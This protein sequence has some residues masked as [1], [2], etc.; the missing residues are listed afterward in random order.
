MSLHKC[1]KEL[2]SSFIQASSVRYS[3]L[4]MS[5][6]CPDQLSHD[7]ISRWLRDKKFQPKKIFEA[8]KNYIDT[9]EPC[10]LIIDD[11]ILSKI[12]SKKIE[13]VNYQ[14]SGNVHD[15]VAGIGLVNLLWYG[16]NSE[17]YVPIDYRIYDKDSDGKTKNTHCLE[18]LN[19]S[20]NRGFNTAVV[21]MDSWYSSL[22][23]LKSIRDMGLTFVTTLRKNRKVNRN[24][25]L[26]ALDI[27]DEGLEIHLRGYG[28]V[29]A[30]KFVAKNGRID[31][32]ITN[33]DNPSRNDV[34]K[35]MK[36]RW[37]I[38]VYHRELKQTC[39]LERCQS[40]NARAQRN[41]IFMS[42]YAWINKF[43]RRVRE[44][45]SFYQQDWDVIKTAISLNMRNIMATS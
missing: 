27:P 25:S 42:I 35:I 1:T 31:Y 28:F 20:Q 12:H 37:K 33:M 6:V 16:L 32:V 40:R 34:E 41:H 3:S 38:E 18:M 7:S 39:G 15:V 10:V 23:N 30:F 44:G 29:T 43:K 26:D 22:K 5:E 36:I 13:L 45:L 24:V 9:Q 19:L 11:T 21:V 8:V 4:A 2:Y 14:Y 17:Q